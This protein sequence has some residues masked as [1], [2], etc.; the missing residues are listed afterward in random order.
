M[1]K[2][3]KGYLTGWV[4]NCNS[5]QQKLIF[6]CPGGDNWPVDVEMPIPFDPVNWFKQKLE[7][8]ATETGIH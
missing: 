5:C 6:L 7:F 2:Q 8:T 1:C 4:E 3:I